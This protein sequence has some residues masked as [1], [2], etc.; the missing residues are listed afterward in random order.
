MNHQIK[1]HGVALPLSDYGTSYFWFDSLTGV[2][3][4]NELFEYQLVVKVRD[5]FHQPAHG[6]AGLEGYVSKHSASSGGTPASDLNL[7]SHWYGTC[8]C[9]NNS[10]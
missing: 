3:K 6:Y 4:L 2:E 10:V 8:E 9:V 7:Q 5:E 1:L